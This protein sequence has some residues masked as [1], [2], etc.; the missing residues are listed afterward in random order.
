M[1]DTFIK[2][3]I[4][5][6]TDNSFKKFLETIILITENYLQ[7]KEPNEK[8]EYE[9]WINNI[10]NPLDW[11][12][13]IPIYGRSLTS[14]IGQIPNNS[15]FNFVQLI[16][17]TKAQEIIK[18]DKKVKRYVK[19]LNMNAKKYLDYFYQLSENTVK[20]IICE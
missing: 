20:E 9:L 16:K 10:Y 18:R 12:Q 15:D 6:H 17:K 1:N 5:I 8:Y 3:N 13:T 11:W 2:E 19:F 14:W 7:K 4:I